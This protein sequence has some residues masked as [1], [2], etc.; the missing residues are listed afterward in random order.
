MQTLTRIRLVCA[1][2][3]PGLVFATPAAAQALTPLVRDGLTPTAS[4][5]FRLQVGNP[6]GKRM[7]FVLIPMLPDLRTPAEGAE[8]RPSRV[9]MAPGHARTVI[10]AFK[11]DPKLKERTVGLCIM[12]EKIEGPILPRV[13]GLYTGRM[14]GGGG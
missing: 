13:C 1:V 3:L 6:Y 11:I 12:P 10:F 8:V 5:A 4:K 9:V 14:A 7:V 2:L